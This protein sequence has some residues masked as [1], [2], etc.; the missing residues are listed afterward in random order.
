[1]TRTFTGRHIA[2]ILV[3][4]FGVVI[5]VNFTM[6]YFA[7]AT[8]GG[9]VVDNSYVASQKFNG[10]LEKARAEK[11]LGWALEGARTADNHVAV[12]L[13][14]AGQAMP[15]ARIDALV[16][17]PLGRAPEQALAFRALGDGRY[18][19]VQ[20]LPAGRWIVHLHA[21]AHGRQLKRIVDLP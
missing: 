11:A 8:F 17:H 20:A 1:M 13:T 3:A 15:E 6:A 16:R 2:A 4:F 9:L 12:T 18:E 21:T 14:S 5:A 19:S 7:S 10:W